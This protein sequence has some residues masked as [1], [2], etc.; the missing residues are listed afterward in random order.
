MPAPLN[1]ASAVVGIARGYIARGWRVAPIPRGKKAPTKPN[2]PDLF[3]SSEDAEEFFGAEVLNIGVILGTASNGLTDVDLD[4][5]EA[6][7]VADRVLP[8][9]TAV[10]GRTAKPRSHFLYYTELAETADKSNEK[11]T[12]PTDHTTLLELRIGGVRAAQTVF[13]GSIHPSGEEIQWATSGD[14]QPVGD[15]ELRQACRTLAAASLLARHWGAP[16]ARND[17][18][19][20]LM[21][22]LL[23]AKWSPDRVG[24]FVD[25]VTVAARGDHELNQRRSDARSA[26]KRIDADETAFGFPKLAELVGETVAAQ[27]LTWLGVQPPPRRPS[28][29]ARG[30]K[31]SSERAGAFEDILAQRFVE[32]NEH[33]F[34]YDLDIERWCLF[35]EDHWNL[36]ARAHALHRLREL[37]RKVGAPTSVM[38]RAVHAAERFAQSDPAITARSMRWDQDPDLLGAPG[39]TIDLKT[40]EVRD[41]RAGDYLTKR[42]A[43]A[44]A[45]QASCPRFRGFI[46]DVAR[47]DAEVIAFLAQWA[48]YCLTGD[49]SEHTLVFLV[50]P[51]GSGK[52]TFAKI[53]AH[54]MGDYAVSA[55]AATFG[56]CRHAPHPAGLAR[57]RGARLVNVAEPDER[58]WN[59]NLIKQFCGGDRI[60]ARALYQEFAEYQ[61]EAKLMF[62]GN[63]LPSL[64]FRD[65]GLQRRLVVIPFEHKPR[66][67]DLELEHE[68]RK[69]G[70]G[71]LRWMLDGCADWR[72]HRLRRPRHAIA[73]TARYFDDADTLRDWF[74]TRC[75]LAT[76]S[77]DLFVTRQDIVNSFE[78]FA[79]ADALKAISRSRLFKFVTDQGA[80][81]KKTTRGGRAVRGF[82]GLRL[83]PEACR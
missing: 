25:I 69:E 74:E 59:L 11:Y 31:T 1:Q 67:P 73:E 43:Y 57:L 4:C 45:D 63:M 80:P 18:R 5:H 64:A 28:A 52:S 56:F 37:A 36:N 9:T 16:C 71:I 40:G 34:R 62:H 77:A 75:E 70:P 54:V 38:S 60:A 82:V 13:P 17:H 65:A 14:P 44:P 66:A 24:E 39:A 49:T 30:L 55:D 26:K 21:G 33:R 47:G 46:E 68:L 61:P 72:A 51:P 48:G 10:F 7:R 79:G 20:A 15:N 29:P 35:S 3:I 76:G 53:I 19:M 50:G 78:N 42:V 2:W 83:A 41:P 8:A 23:R 81:E 27:A 6:E 12:D 32:E 22:A 58:G